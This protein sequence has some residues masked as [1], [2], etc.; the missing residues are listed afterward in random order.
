MTEPNHWQPR[1]PTSKKTKSYS[2]PIR[3]ELPSVF[4]MKTV[5]SY[6]YLEPEPTL[7]DCGENT[8]VSWNTLQAGLAEHQLE[9]ADIQ[10]IIITHAHVDHIGMAGKIS[11]YSGATVWIS[12][13]LREW[14]IH[15]EEMQKVR[16]DTIIGTLEERG[17]SPL[18]ERFRNYFN[19]F[20]SIW[21]VI[22]SNKIAVFPMEGE[23]EFGGQTWQIIYAPG[24]CINQTCFYQAESKQLF[25]ADMLLRITPTPVIDIGLER[26]YKRHKSIFQ[27]LES[28]QKFAVMDIEVVYPGHYEIFYET[29]KLIERQLR[30]IEERK[31]ECLKWIQEGVSDFFVLLLKLYGRQISMPATA[32][33]VGYLDL[34]EAENRIV[35]L[36]T[37]NGLRYY[38]V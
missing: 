19:Q 23:L 6:L 17:N 3:I 38:A 37:D 36:K 29:E 11:E 30:R 15:S 24:H 1:P 20:D 5:N 28:Y 8:M 33:L 32:M 16:F 7:I 14:V 25:S 4:G 34:L 2:S 31:L 10:K 12:E 13:Y 35:V 22:P 27:L 18:I 21:S 26:P 9:V